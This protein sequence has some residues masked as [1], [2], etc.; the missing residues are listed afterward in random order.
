MKALKYL[1]IALAAFSSLSASASLPGPT[2][3]RLP[4]LMRYLVFAKGNIQSQ[5]S[6]YQGNTGAVGEI[7]LAHFEI[8]GNLE[9]N[10][11][12]RMRDGS[13]WGAGS[14][15][16]LNLLRVNNRHQR[17]HT[18]RVQER[19]EL[20]AFGMDYASMWLNEMNATSRP[21]AARESINGRSL[22]GL[23]LVAAR[24]VE[25][26]DIEASAL[27]SA[28]NLFLEG[29]GSSVLLLRIRGE[30]V[31]MSRKGIFV[32]RGLRPNQI[33][34]LFPEAKK[35]HLAYSGGAFDPDDRRVHWGIPGSILAPRADLHFA[36]ALVTGKLYAKNI[37]TRPGLNGGQVNYGD[38]ILLECLLASWQVCPYGQPDQ[39]A[40]KPGQGAK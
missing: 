2:S 17:P 40:A 11:R 25:V 8:Q 36:E 35:I 37:L 24:P 22:L 1:S 6:D 29:N 27:N 5:H 32:T 16:R 15:P 3:D 7:D 30:K 12:V 31:N 9:S 19:I 13:I 18:P 28:D 14:A 4:D 20:A 33:V 26:I 34:Y 38:S 23:K 39:P 10:L 21:R